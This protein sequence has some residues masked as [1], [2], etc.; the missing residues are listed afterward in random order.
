MQ[1]LYTNYV[2]IMYI[3][4]YYACVYTLLQ[5]LRKVTEVFKLHK[6]FPL[7]NKAFLFCMLSYSRF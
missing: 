7:Q 4:V 2:C 5:P 3:C 1:A 6:Q